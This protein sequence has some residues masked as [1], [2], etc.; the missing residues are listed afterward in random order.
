MRKYVDGLGTFN[1]NPASKANRFLQS[2]CSEQ[3]MAIT[4]SGNSEFVTPMKLRK[5]GAATSMGHHNIKTDYLQDFVDAPFA[6]TMK[7]PL[8]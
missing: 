3:R 4:A 8:R 1:K 7:Q 5:I 6:K 2:R